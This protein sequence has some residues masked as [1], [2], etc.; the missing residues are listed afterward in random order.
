MRWEF[1]FRPAAWETKWL[2]NTQANIDR[3]KK[4]KEDQKRLTVMD[5][6]RGTQ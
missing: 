1:K 6:V 3:I 4:K 5:P 2:Q